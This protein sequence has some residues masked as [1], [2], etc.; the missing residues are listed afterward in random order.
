MNLAEERQAV[1]ELLTA[2]GVRAVAHVPSKPTPPLAMVV[3]GSPYLSAAETFGGSKALRLDVW[4]VIGTA[5]GN[6]ALTDALDAEI[7]KALAILEADEWLI[8]DVQIDQWQ[9]AASAIE[10]PVAIIGIRTTITP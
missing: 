6:A 4:L 8:E 3:P 2:G 9:P 5:T 10:Y 1:A 7:V